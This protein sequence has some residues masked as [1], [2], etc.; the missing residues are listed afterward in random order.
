ELTEVPDSSAAAA[1]AYKTLAAPGHAILVLDSTGR[2]LAGTWSG[3][4]IDQAIVARGEP[5]VWTA[6]TPGGA[7]RAHLRPTRDHAFLL[8]CAV[9]LADMLREQREAEEAIRT[10]LPIVR[11][12]AAAG[13]LWLASIGLRPITEMA[14]RAEGL[15]PAG[16]EDFGES[17]RGDELGQFARAFNGLVARLR[18]A[19]Q[20]QRQFM[21]DAS[22]E[23]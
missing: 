5:V 1:E 17:D 9:P 23:L 18:Q 11:L 8:F 14:R 16:M 10:G 15:A 7:W 19:L 22:H 6:A 4:T 2:V 3:P 12:L 13:G 20:T 21:A